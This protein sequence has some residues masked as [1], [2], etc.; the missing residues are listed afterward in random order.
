MS[1][2][3]S[4]ANLRPLNSL[5][6]AQVA[7]ALAH[8]TSPALASPD[9]P[10][11]FTNPT[12]AMLA[13]GNMYSL[14]HGRR[15]LCVV[16]AP[17]RLAQVDDEVRVLRAKLPTLV[18]LAQKSPYWAQ[19]K[20]SSER[21]NKQLLDR[22]QGDGRKDLADGLCRHFID[23]LFGGRAEKDDELAQRWIRVLRHWNAQP[24]NTR[25]K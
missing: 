11:W 20:A 21:Y 1:T 15:A 12:I 7:L 9:D 18:D 13:A 17:D 24:S 6:A 3:H 25:A 4:T 8:V 23:N 16:V 22:A 5:K 2:F 14:V 10:A 19:G